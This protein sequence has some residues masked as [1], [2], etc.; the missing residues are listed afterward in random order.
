MLLFSF[1]EQGFTLEHMMASEG[2]SPVKQ[3]TETLI[4]GSGFF[5]AQAV[6]QASS[7]AGLS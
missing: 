6:A 7:I 4:D 1:H 2:E 5:C 3:R